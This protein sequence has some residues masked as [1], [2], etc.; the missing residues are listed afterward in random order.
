MAVAGTD[1]VH[2]GVCVYVLANTCYFHV[3]FTCLT[4]KSN[5]TLSHN[6]WRQQQ[7]HLSYQVQT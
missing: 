4:G 5:V 1:V 2:G 3:K 6:Q 7:H